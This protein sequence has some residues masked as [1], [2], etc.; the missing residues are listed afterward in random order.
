M[1]WSIMFARVTTTLL[2]SSTNLHVQT[3]IQSHIHVVWHTCSMVE[4]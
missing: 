3:S 2:Q 1:L 4:P